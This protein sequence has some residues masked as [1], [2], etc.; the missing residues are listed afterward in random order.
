MAYVVT[1]I[2]RFQFY[3]RKLRENLKKSEEYRTFQH[4]FQI[5]LGICKNY[6][7]HVTPINCTYV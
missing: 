3:Y 5:Y 6:A 2:E 1:N 7:V 4:T